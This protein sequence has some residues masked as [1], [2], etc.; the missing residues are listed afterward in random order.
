MLSKVKQKVFQRFQLTLITLISFSSLADEISVVT[1]YLPPFQI[2]AEDGSLSGF[3]TDVVQA[4][5]KSVGDQLNIKVFPWARA[6]ETASSVKNTMIF[7][8]AK[9]EERLE[10]FLWVG[11]LHEIRAYFW[12]LKTQFPNPPYPVD[13]LKS[14]RIATALNSSEFHYLKHHNFTNIYPVSKE[15]FRLTMIVKKRTDIIYETV[16][17]FYAISEAQGLDVNLFTK[18]TPVEGD[19]LTLSIA[20]NKNSDADLVSKYQQAFI[21]L[22]HSGKFKELQEKW[23]LTQ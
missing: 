5:A 17:S 21:K 3:S 15:E 12:G 6:Y 11:D 4:L 7:S 10:K 23:K 18:L 22:T 9:S 16:P 1:E 13:E 14:Y 8:M 2:Q 20:F 19:N